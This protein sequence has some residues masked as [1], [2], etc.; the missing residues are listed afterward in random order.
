MRRSR[1]ALFAVPPFVALIA[2]APAS[3]VPPVDPL[4]PENACGA[5]RYQSLVGTAVDAAQFAGHDTVRII[6]PGTAVTMD[7]RPTRLNVE[8]DTAGVITRIYCG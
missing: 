4:P 8:T 7:Y 5:E 6:P 1:F 3:D 2:C